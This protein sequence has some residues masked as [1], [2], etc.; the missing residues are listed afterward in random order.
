MEPLGVN[1]MCAHLY[2]QQ[3][4]AHCKKRYFHIDC[5]L[6]NFC[7]LLLGLEMRLGAL[8]AS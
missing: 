1:L 8:T 2:V 3:E 4:C 5:Q 6:T 7:Y